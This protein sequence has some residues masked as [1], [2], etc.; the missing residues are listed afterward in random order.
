MPKTYDE[1][2]EILSQMPQGLTF[3]EMLAELNQRL[4]GCGWSDAD[5]RNILVHL[6][7]NAA[8]Y[9]WTFPHVSSNGDGRYVMAIMEKDGTFTLDDQDKAS[10]ESGME[11]TLKRIIQQLSNNAAALDMAAN[12]TSR[13]YGDELKEWA[14]DCRHEANHGKRILRKI[15]NDGDG[16]HGR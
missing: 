8:H 15:Q 2:I 1:I 16:T 13:R 4:P 3:K 5:L 9:G 14:A 7:K 10:V 12:N 6:R 11:T